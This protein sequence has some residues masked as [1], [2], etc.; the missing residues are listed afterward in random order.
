MRLSIA[1][2]RKKIFEQ[3]IMRLSLSPPLFK[4]RVASKNV[5]DYR[6]QE[7]FPNMPFNCLECAGFEYMIENFIREINL[8]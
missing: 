4:L 3:R 6:F 7:N 8:C 5:V 2:Y 1:I